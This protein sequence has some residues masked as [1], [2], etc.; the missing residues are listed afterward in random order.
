[1]KLQNSMRAF[2]MQY[3]FAVSVFQFYKNGFLLLFKRL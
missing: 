2:F 1:M 3:H